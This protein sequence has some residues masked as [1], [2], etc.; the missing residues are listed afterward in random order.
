MYFLFDDNLDTFVEFKRGE[1]LHLLHYY[2]IRYYKDINDDHIEESLYY[3]IKKRSI[4]KQRIINT[5]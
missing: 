1:E 5:F 3:N 4:P 2:F